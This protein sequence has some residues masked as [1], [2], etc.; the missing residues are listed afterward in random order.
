MADQTSDLAG[1][2]AYVR[3]LAEEGRNAPLVNGL[4]Y[5]IWG[6]LITAGALVEYAVRTQ[7][8][9]VD[10]AASWFIWL[11]VFALG[12]G[13]SRLAGARMGR[14]PGAQSIGNRTA[15]SAWLAVGLFA[16][17]F[18]L[19]MTLAHDNYAHEGVPD[20]F[21]FGTLFPVA[22]GLYGIAFF[23]TATAAQLPWLRYFA[24]AAWAFSFAA[25]FLL[26][27]PAQ[28]LLAAA[29]TFACAVVPGVMLMRREP[30]DIV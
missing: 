2:I 10:G 29:G 13:A 1:E 3:A 25:L 23:A 11:S 24:F 30:S 19:T 6:G 26:G 9:E 15:A 8:L 27:Q 28:M 12:W 22:F 4:F 21:L 16:T 20:Y 17:G 7:I 18:W 5:V 14:K